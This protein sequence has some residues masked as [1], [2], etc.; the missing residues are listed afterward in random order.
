MEEERLRND[1]LQ[2]DRKHTEYLKLVYARHKQ[3]RGF[4]N[5]IIGLFLMESELE[6]AT[7]WLLKHHMD[8]GQTLEQGQVDKVFQK[9]GELGYWETQLHL[10]QILPNVSASSK[11]MAILEPHIRKLFGSDKKFVKAAAYP[12]YLEIVKRFPELKNDF[13]DSCQEALIRESASVRV[14]IKRVV[15]ALRRHS[16]SA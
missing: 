1:L 2:W 8:H 12:A 9:F 7:S 14:K 15:E 3:D 6:H 16:D 5:L 11:Q 4:I 10:L 13:L